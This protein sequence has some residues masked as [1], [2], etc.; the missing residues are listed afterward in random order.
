MSYLNTFIH[1]NSI[2]GDAEKIQIGNYHLR[3]TRSSL[4]SR[5]FSIV[6]PM[7]YQIKALYVV[8]IKF[9]SQHRGELHQLQT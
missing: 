4:C 9:I 7:G 6:I 2:I 5:T 3:H 1:N 8:N